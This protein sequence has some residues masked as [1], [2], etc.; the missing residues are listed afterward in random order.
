MGS[1][2]SLDSEISRNP[3]FPEFAGFL[4][5]PESGNH[6]ILKIPGIP[7]IPAIRWIPGLPGPSDFDIPSRSSRPCKKIIQIDSRPREREMLEASIP[8]EKIKKDMP[9]CKNKK[10]DNWNYKE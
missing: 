2:H 9:P 3:G 4:G 7:K 6:A 8:W 1:R 5:P 10:Y